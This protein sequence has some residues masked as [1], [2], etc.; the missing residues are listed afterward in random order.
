[1]P[2]VMLADA[3][4]PLVLTLDLGTSSIRAIVYDA[5]ARAV[6]GLAARRRC[7][8]ELT[9]E[10][11]A[12]LEPRATAA[13]LAAVVDEILER[14]GGRIKIEAVASSSLAYNALALGAS[15]EIL[16]PAILYSDTRSA[17]A[18]QNLRARIDW[19]PIYARTG[20]PLHAGYMP[21]RIE[22]LREAR[23]DL[24]ARVAHWFSLYEFF[25]SRLFGRTAV[26]HSFASWSGLMD[27]TPLDWDDE[28][29]ELVGARREQFAP[30]VSASEPLV[31]LNDEFARRW[32]ALAQ[33]PW[34]P[35]LGDGA[36][37]NIGS[38]CTD[39]RRVAVTVG[40]SGAMRVVMP[41]GEAARSLPQGLWMYRLDEAD[42]VLGG[43]LN[44]GGNVFAY[45][46]ALLV[47]P[48]AA[49]LEA[50]VAAQEP[51]A[52]GL[53][54]LPFFAGERSPGYRGDARAAL[55]GWTLST[56]P[57]QIW[58]CALEAISY[59]F[60]ALYELL[61][62]VIPAPLE[63]VASGAAL[64]SSPAWA[65]ILAD[66]LGAPVTM[67]GELEASARGGALVALRSL[68]VIPSLDAL[69]AD[70]G[71]TFAPRP[72]YYEVYTRA[73]ERQKRL[74]HLFYPHDL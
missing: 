74:Y 10:G 20:C 59:R 7:P 18:A 21:A 70:R 44:E 9:E 61:R 29:L 73:R 47:L 5:R 68:G 30:V 36:L 1:M 62:R 63:I 71:A 35:A 72:A 38:G 17:R 43:S 48:E 55:D 64:L 13:L 19:R 41:A 2:G 32:P 39:A 8:V 57:V 23:P 11:G 67:A 52:H 25:L 54:L 28:V 3:V 50:Q 24:E 27:Q 14:G 65:Q 4:P 56:S 66:V 58:R 22:W 46:S 49:D 37:A 69:P 60:A 6:D 12:T 42:A 31:G 15:G 34:Y 26:S 45:F 53:T 51:D 33:V 40:T 16:T